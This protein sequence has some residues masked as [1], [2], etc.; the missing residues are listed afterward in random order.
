MIDIDRTNNGR[1]KVEL[2]QDILGDSYN[3]SASNYLDYE[4]RLF[5]SKDALRVLKAEDVWCV[6][7]E[8]LIEGHAVLGMK[9]SIDD[10]LH[11]DDF[12]IGWFLKKE[13]QVRLNYT[14]KELDMIEIKE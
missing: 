10:C 3:F 12:K 2:I 4:P 9:T 8:S 5:I 7:S 11:G 1:S 6:Y 14:K 13:K